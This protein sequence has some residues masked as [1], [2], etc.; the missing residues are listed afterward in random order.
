MLLC[1][2]TSLWATNNIKIFV[3]SLDGKALA[4]NVWNAYQTKSDSKWT[5][6]NSAYGTDDE[7]LGNV[8]TETIGGETWYYDL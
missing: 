4:I 7:Q 3:R 6:D 8:Q 2:S 5:D 1:A